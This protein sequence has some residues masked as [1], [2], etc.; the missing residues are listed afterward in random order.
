MHKEKPEIDPIDPIKGLGK[1]NFQNIPIG[2]FDIGTVEALLSNPIGFM[3]LSI[4]QK[5]ELFL[6]DKL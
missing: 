5:A 4:F 6:R 3:D 2:P 1:I